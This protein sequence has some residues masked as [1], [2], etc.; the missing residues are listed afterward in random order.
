MDYEDFV[1]QFRVRTAQRMEEFEKA[2]AKA[3][4]DAAAA[5]PETGKTQQKE[6]ENHKKQAAPEKPVQPARGR[7]RGWVRGRGPVQSV[8]RKA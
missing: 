5:V 3:Q 2:L 4:K 1:T 7:V 6:K 8:L